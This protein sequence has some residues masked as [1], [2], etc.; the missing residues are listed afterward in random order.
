MNTADKSI[1]LVD[2]AIRRRFEFIEISPDSSLI[3]DDKVKVVL[4]KINQSIE[5]ENPNLR[6]LLIGHS[7]FIDINWSELE[8]VINRQIIPLLY[9]YFYDNESKVEKILVALESLNIKVNKISY[10]RLSVVVS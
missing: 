3:T 10:K 5:K 9:E 8:H 7:Y 2:T 4:E 6:D 1:S